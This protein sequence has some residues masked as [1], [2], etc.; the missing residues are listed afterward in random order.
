MNSNKYRGSLRLLM[1]IVVLLAV[2]GGI[3]GGRVLERRSLNKEVAQNIQTLREL[4]QNPAQLIQQSSSA[5]L[6][7]DKLSLA[8]ALIEREY[9]DS[10]SI[11][12]LRE[13]L[14]PHIFEK[15]DPHSV[16]IPASELEEMN[17]PLEGE[18]DGVGIVFNMATDTVLVIN[19]IPSGPSADVGIVG[20][21]RIIKINDSLV[22]GVKLPQHDVIKRLRGKR[23]T[24]VKLGVERGGIDEL[25]EFEV[26]RD[27]IPI[28]SIS[29]AI[30]LKDSIGYIRM[31]QFARTT[32]FELVAAIN[33]LKEQG[34]KGLILDLRGNTGGYLDQAILIAN[35]FLPDNKLIVYTEDRAGKRMNQ[36]SDGYGILKEMNIALLIDE[37]SASSS[38]IL[39]G[40]LQDNDI[41]TIVGRR[42][43]GKGLVQQQIPF[44]DG[45]AMRLTIARYYT[46]VGR[47]IQK[48]YGDSI[49]YDEDLARRIEHNEFFVADSIHFADSLK[50]TTPKGKIVYGGGG[51][52][53][54]VFVPADTTAMSKY[55][56]EVSLKNILY[57]YTTKYA[58]DNR[59]KINSITTPEQLEEL[60]SH[61]ATNEKLLAGFVAYA[62]K[63]GVEPVWDEIETSREIILAQLKAYIGRNTPLDDDAFTLS[64]YPIDNTILKAIEIIEQKDKI[65][66]VPQ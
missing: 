42:S 35:E 40:A 34:L 37:Q 54:D 53:P 3:I 21:D 33:R 65:G 11:D 4:S 19:V 7:N 43:F 52:M 50:F 27:A 60:F 5:M 61:Y 1:P 49:A 57:N 23:G 9:V 24:Q 15:L 62:E 59:E 30:I 13:H 18:F 12:T 39:A 41:G 46:P 28:N 26:T 36:Y 14:M 6:S 64:I 32:H 48:E 63:R 56:M 66:Q 8:L 47:S 2:T 44:L 29:S 22:A 45:S 38:E 16:Y 51:I 17:E 31:L 58:D 10:V 55:F 25:I 20:G